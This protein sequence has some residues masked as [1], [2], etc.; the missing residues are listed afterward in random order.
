MPDDLV[1]GL[2]AGLRFET[3]VFHVGQYCGRWRASTAGRALASYHL[4]LEGR[5][6]AHI[7]GRAPLELG[8]RDGLFFL[9]D[10][11]HFLSVD[12]N[13]A[14]LAQGGAPVPMRPLVPAAPDGV[15]L[16]CGFFHFNSGGAGEPALDG[17]PDHLIIR[18]GTPGLAPASTIFDLILAESNH[19]PERPSPLVARLVDVLFY[20]VLRHAVQVDPTATGLWALARHGTFAGLVQAILNDPGAGWSVESMAR[21][22]HMSRA[23]F[24][25]HFV[26]VGGSSPAEV[27]L[28]IRMRVA[29]QRIQSGDAISHAAEQVG[30]QSLAAFSR[31]FKRAMGV[32]PSAYRPR[33]R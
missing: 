8:P 18:A 4:V 27:L 16:A 10:I 24:F 3:S 31:A 28:L 20:Y 33:P 2:L 11:P 14:A 23:S 21:A 15:G 5:C 7:E 9:R 30:Y 1:Q 13:P 12:A 6:H 19:P 32:S 25:K 26:D 17:L 29:A 22:A